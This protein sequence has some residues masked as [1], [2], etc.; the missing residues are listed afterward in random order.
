MDIELFEEFAAIAK[1][2]NLSEAAKELHTTQPALSRHLAALEKRFSVKLYDRTTTP[3]ELTVEGRDFL[4][5]AGTITS[6]YCALVDRMGYFAKTKPVTLRVCG[7]IET[8][9]G[10]LFRAAYR[11]FRQDNERYVVRFITEVTQTP[12]DLLRDDEIDLA[13]EP[14]SDYI[15]THGLASAPLAS[16]PS[17]VLY[18]K[19]TEPDGIE[20]LDPELL[21]RATFSSI[22]TNKDHANRK[23]IQHLCSLHGLP[24]AVPNGFQLVDANSYPE[25]LM[26]GLADSYVMLPESMAKRLAE[27]FSSEYTAIPLISNDADTDYHFRLFYRED[28]DKHVLKFVEAMQKTLSDRNET[29]E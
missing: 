26:Q 27:M 8:K 5:Y 28:A 24:G 16:E 13:I 1:H 20:F 12:F 11:S 7:L 3:M 22:R 4:K 25:L 23:H 6:A 29:S 14:Q 2:N 10:A 21:P 17:W 9:V 18:E 15:D 19:G